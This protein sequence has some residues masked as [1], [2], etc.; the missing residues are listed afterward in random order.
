MSLPEIPDDAVE[1]AW[2]YAELDREDM[3]VVRGAIEAAWP[4]LV[5][6]TLRHTRDRALADLP[7]D[8]DHDRAIVAGLLDEWADEALATVLATSPP[9]PSR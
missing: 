4:A 1:L 5:A 9:P 8:A 7:F 6:A 2:T 3:P